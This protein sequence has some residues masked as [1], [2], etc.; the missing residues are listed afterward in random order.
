M[1]KVKVKV[2]PSKPGVGRL[3]DGGKGLLTL[4]QD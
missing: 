2:T 3:I 1:V 4:L